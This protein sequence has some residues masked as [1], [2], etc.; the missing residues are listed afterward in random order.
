MNKI[1]IWHNPR[2]T[3]SREGVAIVEESKVEHEIIKY[4]D[5]KPSVKEL[6]A[7]LKMLGFKS[8]REWMRTKEAIYK[9]LNLK[10]ETDEEKLLEAMAEHPKLIERPV[11]I[12]G[13]KAIIGRPSSIVADFLK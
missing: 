3:K 4:L 5:D 8:A 2:C 11:I 13:D 6:K 10:D 1:T 7:V 9:E 12:K